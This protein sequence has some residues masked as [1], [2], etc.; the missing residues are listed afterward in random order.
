[1]YHLVTV[2]VQEH[3]AGL[4]AEVVHRYP[5]LV[6]MRWCSPD[7]PPAGSF[8][9][10]EDINV[11]GHTVRIPASLSDNSDSPRVLLRF[12]GPI[13]A[14]WR[15]RLIDAGLRIRFSCPPTGLC[16]DRPAPDAL[17]NLAAT[18]P[19]IGLA[20]YD[21]ALCQRPVSAMT[22]GQRQQ[23]GVAA[24]WLD[25][26]LFDP[27]ADTPLRE[28]IEQLG[29]RCL[30]QS[31]YKLR[32]ATSLP[33]A[34]FRQL[35]GVKLANPAR[36]PLPTYLPLRDALGIGSP[37]PLDAQGFDGAGETV[38]IV[39][40]GLD[41]G[42]HAT[43]HDDLAGRLK[44]LNSW[45]INDSWSAFIRTPAA[46]DGGADTHSGHG[47]HV[48]GLVAGNGRRS[49]GRIAGIAPACE[50]VFQ[51]IEQYTEVRPEYRARLPSG[52]YLNG[53]PLDLRELF[54]SSA[55]AG[56]FVHVNAWGDPAR[57]DY[58]DDC[59]ETDHFL[60]HHPEHVAIF[61]AGNDGADHDG[62]GV[63][64][65]GSLYAPGSAKNVLTVGATEGP[66][67][68][69]GWRGSWGDMD[70][71]RTRYRHPD[72]RQDG[73]SGDTDQCALFSSCGPTRDGRIKP[74]LCAPG[75][76]LPA[77][78]ASATR[79]R[80]WGLAS[81]LPHYMYYGG[82]SM[83]TGVVGG[84]MALLRQAWRRDG[85]APSGP[86]LKALCML[87][88]T[89]LHNPVTQ[90]SEPRH[91]GGFGR[92]NLGP[93]LA[94]D[95]HDRITLHD[96]AQPL[97]TG[98]CWAL[99][100]Q[101][102]TQ[103]HFSAVLSWYDAPGEALI[104]QL[105]LVLESDGQLLAWGNHPEGDVGAPDRVNN[106]QRLSLFALP[107]GHYS[108]RVLAIAL[109]EGPQAFALAHSVVPTSQPDTKAPPS[110]TLLPVHYL[111]GIGA[112][113]AERL[114]E[115]NIHAIS[116]L[117][118]LPPVTLAALLSLSAGRKR[119]LSKRLAQLSAL[120]TD[121]ALAQDLTLTEA[122]ASGHPLAAVLTDIFDKA[123]WD[124]IRL[125]QLYHPPGR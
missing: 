115:Q 23:A 15:Q 21:E 120:Q 119:R 5:S 18:L 116:E 61:A 57:G 96:L 8:P 125:Q 20:A 50:L 72:S 86:A 77:T 25:L 73:V 70:P 40:T 30:A 24:D 112:V 82:T 80:G 104:Q 94:A 109:P 45:P 44:R 99:D 29:A 31:H 38:A 81:P 7:A 9:L 36:A 58:T 22:P 56:A 6:L 48:A 53:R 91:A 66:Q 90:Q 49:G 114:R 42:R 124:E 28:H 100:F 47:T 52:Y 54:A 33:A 98:A 11:N 26:V 2:P 87:A 69:V 108:L 78:R 10:S 55:D 121:P 14:A 107:A 34:V 35:P 71:G 17:A 62:D 105:A 68:G 37:Q 103:Q 92:F 1:M 75:T 43:V 101:L 89:P 102:K 39:D 3:W 41:Q 63:I 32:V 123:C 46:D 19:L 79:A 122:Q 67:A 13:P 95:R 4:G 113:Y 110:P 16:V 93:L 76:N 111:K 51:A 97:E 117:Q 88:A 27:V 106:V 59:Y 84:A 74:D 83:A 118:Q 60:F 85:Q 12:A 64:D 65:P